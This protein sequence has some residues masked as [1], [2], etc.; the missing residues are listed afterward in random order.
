MRKS[1]RVG[2]TAEKLQAGFELSGID[3][4]RN[5]LQRVLKALEQGSN[6]QGMPTPA[7]GV[8]CAWA[9]SS[10]VV[11]AQCLAS[12]ARLGEI[13]ALTSKWKTL[14]LKRRIE[15][16]ALAPAIDLPVSAHVR[17]AP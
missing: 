13:H 16:S 10:S 7:D 6:P 2:A 9:K 12:F 15:S 3:E 4:V 1:G 17:F 8:R 5:L 11:R 14:V